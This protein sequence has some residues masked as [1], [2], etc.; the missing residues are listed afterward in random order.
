MKPLTSHRIKLKMERGKPTWLHP[1]GT[2]AWRWYCR[3]CKKEG[4]AAYDDWEYIASLGI[5]H[6]KKH[7]GGRY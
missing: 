6:A 2:T 1:E 3:T 7:H 4:R 5:G